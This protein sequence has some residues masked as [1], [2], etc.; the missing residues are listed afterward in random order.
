MSPIGRRTIHYTQ[1]P[2]L[3]PGD[4]HYHEWNTYRRELPRL[5]AEGHED[6]FALINSHVVIG[7]FDSHDEADRVGLRLY[8]GKVFAVQPIRA[9]EPIL[10]LRGYNL[11]YP[12]S[13]SR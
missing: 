11:P 4:E 8:L 2:D 6:K 9:E 5:L 10:R 1:L 7:V 13:L 12:N 3:P